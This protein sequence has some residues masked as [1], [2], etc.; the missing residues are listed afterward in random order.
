MGNLTLEPL[1]ARDD[2]PVPAWQ[3]TKDVSDAELLGRYVAG[4]DEAAFVGL[5]Q[6][7]ARLVWGVCRRVHR[8]VH[9]AE[10]SF[11]ATFFVLAR[12]AGTIRSAGA[13]AGWLY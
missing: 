9:D 1:A 7:H 4:R 5:M 13:L 11:Q 2:V 12:K 3:A 10:D 6:R 8:N